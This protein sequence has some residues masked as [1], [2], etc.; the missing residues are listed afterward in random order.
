MKCK[1]IKISRISGPGIKRSADGT[2]KKIENI[3]NH[4]IRSAIKI[5][6]VLL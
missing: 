1:I 3:M 5:T 6:F 4:H 2:G